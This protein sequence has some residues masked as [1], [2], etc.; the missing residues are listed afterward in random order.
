MIICT[1]LDTCP[2]AACHYRKD[3]IK[4][5]QEL[6]T[7]MESNQ[8]TT[9]LQNRTAPE[10]A[11]GETERKTEVKGKSGPMWAPNSPDIVQISKLIAP[12]ED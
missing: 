7:E 10:T 3:S 12:L 1:I 8:V 4:E 11:T 6:K 5:K 9:V 2:E